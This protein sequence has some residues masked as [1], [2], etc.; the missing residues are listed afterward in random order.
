MHPIAVVSGSGLCLDSLLDTTEER[1][2]FNRFPGLL[3]ASVPGHSGEYLMGACAGTRIILQRG[4]LHF[5]EG[6]SYDAVVR[7]VDVLLE[8]GARSVVFTNAVGGLLLGMRPG[9]LLAVDRVRL[10]RYT[11]WPATP[12]T[13]VPD[14][15]VP[16]CDFTG[17]MQWVPG[18]SYET[19][20]EIAM[21]QHY[22]MAAVGMSTAPELMR[23]QELGMPAAV[24]SCVTNSCCR[25][26]PLSHHEVVTAAGRASNR[27]AALLRRFIATSAPCAPQSE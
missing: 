4:R 13:L 20:A 16:D 11:G 26:A 15:S 17:P 23:A 9:D 24:V 7:T 25:P 21:F 10:A 12:G 1:V 18:P 19:R 3:Q 6:L 14:S 22:H 2:P 8:L 5:Y 27:M